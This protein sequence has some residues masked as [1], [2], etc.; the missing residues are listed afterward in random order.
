MGSRLNTVTLIILMIVSG[1]VGYEIGDFRVGN[2]FKEK[3]WEEIEKSKDAVK[4]V[5]IEHKAEITEINTKYK[6]EMLSADTKYENLKKQMALMIKNKDNK[7]S[8]LDKKIVKKNEIINFKKGEVKSL[9]LEKAKL[10]LKAS[11]NDNKL[12]ELSAKM[13]KKNEEIKKLQNDI[14]IAKEEKEGLECLDKY[15]PK[16]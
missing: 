8:E 5:Q 1:L 12:S 6:K 16:M 13:K 11:T 7:I 2:F 4:L 9:L 10:K 15:V 3:L 14:L